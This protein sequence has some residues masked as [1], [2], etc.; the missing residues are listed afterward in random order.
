[1]TVVKVTYIQ[2]KNEG[3]MT[4]L[5]CHF[6]IIDNHTSDCSQISSIYGYV[7]N[8]LF[9]HRY[10]EDHIILKGIEM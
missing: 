4:H 8:E 7:F 3:G 1:M 9:I 6:G 5:S 10:A 2:Y